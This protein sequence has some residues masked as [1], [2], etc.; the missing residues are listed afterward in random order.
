MATK[1]SSKAGQWI[2]AIDKPK[3]QRK[4]A[5]TKLSQAFTAAKIPAVLSEKRMPCGTKYKVLSIRKD[6]GKDNPTDVQ[7]WFDADGNFF[8]MGI[9][10][11][12]R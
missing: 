10:K 5:L 4:S 6:F 1:K 11:A 7:F 12:E 8:L 2:A 9:C 3:E